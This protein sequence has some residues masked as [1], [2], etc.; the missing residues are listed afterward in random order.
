MSTIAVT[1]HMDLTDDTVPLVRAELEQLLQQETAAE[2]VGLSCI[3]KGADSLSRRRCSP[4]EGAWSWWCRVR[5]TGR[6]R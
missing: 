1:G 2:L 6:R 5:T 4:R 3:A